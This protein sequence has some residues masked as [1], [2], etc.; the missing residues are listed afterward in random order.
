MGSVTAAVRRSFARLWFLYLA[1][2]LMCLKTAVIQRFVFDLPIKGW[3]QEL[4]AAI[5]PISSVLLFTWL[6]LLLARRRKNRAILIVS[7][8]TSFLLF[9]NAWYYRFFN[10]F[11]TLPVLFQTRNASDLG[12]S[13][14]TLLYPTDLFFFTDFII[15][16]AIAAA[17]KLP[18]VRVKAAELSTMF[19]LAVV[20]FLI[21]LG[22]AE[23]VR[24]ELL[25]RTFDRNILVK[26]IGTYNY[27]LYD[28]VVSSK[29]QTQRAFATSEE[30]AVV[31][32]YV[33]EKPSAEAGAPADLFG[34]AEGKNIVLVSMES[35]QSFVIGN[36]VFG[37]EITPFLNELIEES[38]Y[39]ENFYHQTG[40]G[41]TSDA[42][43]IIDNSLYPLP[44]G[45][46]YFTHATN[47]YNSTPK[48]L[49]K[50]GYYAASLHANDK[51]FWNRDIMYGNLGYDRF[52]SKSDYD[53]T[54][55]NSVGWGLKD[56][57]FFEQS[58]E[59]LKSLP[60]PFY[61]KLITLTNHHPFS[62]A[63]ADEYVPEFDSGDG[64]FDRYFTTVRYMD[65][66][67]KVFFERMKEAGLY[68]NSIFV[69]YGDHYGISANHYEAMARYLGKEITPYDHIQ[70][71]RVPLIIHIPGVEGRK[72]A[73]IAG[74]IDVRPTLLHL[75]G[76]E[77]ENELDFGE[78]LF[79]DNPDPLIVLRDGS[80]ITN[81]YLYTQ[82]VCYRKAYFPFE[83]DPAACE[84]YKEMA[85]AELEHSDQII[86]GDLMRFKE[87]AAPDDASDA[88]PDP[89]PAYAVPDNAP[90]GLDEEPHSDGLYDEFESEAEAESSA[91]A[92]SKLSAEAGEA[93]NAEA[94]NTA[95]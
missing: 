63:R 35:L 73:K 25:T 40:Q 22:M 12:I 53:V 82:N 31:E 81:D 66:A 46:V 30:L 28:I 75:L 13:A 88:V 70:L 55:E 10:D 93:G 20:I 87:N 6:A 9:A 69:L 24:P 26:S 5:T 64:T 86:Y 59:H 36:T 43:F 2:F 29:A 95:E 56:I 71:Q 11:I 68:E 39:F 51:T 23:S 50:Y 17:R 19:A 67:L 94:E 92:Q 45:A 33:K 85:A 76:I 61:G 3:Y 79:A 60:Q 91:E 57:P 37:H 83:T 80:F 7:F 47:A 58:V 4:I 41:K 48:I 34:I 84:T 32:S 14:F 15:L 89:A 74:Q 52:F 8:I 27:H 65:E 18:Q 77:G 90:A 62:L 1:V 42:E 21:N 72:V 54:S 16:A 49:K 78:N 44:S 38:F